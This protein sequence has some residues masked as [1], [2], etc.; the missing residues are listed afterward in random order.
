[1]PKLLKEGLEE[2]AIEVVG[3]CNSHPS[4]VSR[5]IS[6]I[7]TLVC[8]LAA[9]SISGCA[10]QKKADCAN[11]KAEQFAVQK[12]DPS[13]WEKYAQKH[14]LNPA[15]S[16]V[17]RLAYEKEGDKVLPCVSDLLEN[18][19]RSLSLLAE[20]SENPITGNCSILKHPK[21]DATVYDAM[22]GRMKYDKY[23]PPFRSALDSKHFDPRTFA[24]VFGDSHGWEE[25]IKFIAE[26][27]NNPSY[28]PRIFA[29]LKRIGSIRVSTYHIPLIHTF[30]ELARKL[31]IK[32]PQVLFDFEDSLIK[33]FSSIKTSPYGAPTAANALKEVIE[34]NPIPSVSAI[35]RDIVFLHGQSEGWWH[36]YY[37]LEPIVKSPKYSEIESL[38]PKFIRDEYLVT[39]LSYAIQNRNFD[40][41]QIPAIEKAAK[42]TGKNA[43]VLGSYLKHHDFSKMQAALSLVQMYSKHDKSAAI[44]NALSKYFE[45]PNFEFSN[46]QEVV[47]L[48]IEDQKLDFRPLSSPKADSK[49]LLALSKV[50]AATPEDTDDSFGRSS[51]IDAFT[52]LLGKNAFQTWMLDYALS[53]GNMPYTVHYLN[54][55]LDKITTSY[56]K[57]YKLACSLQAPC[58]DPVVYLN[59]AYGID[60]FGEDKVKKL[61]QQF[62]IRYFSRYKPE[63]LEEMLSGKPSSKPPLLAV[64]T[65]A[66]WNGAFTHPR[67]LESLSEN[68]NLT[69]IETGSEEE[70]LQRLGV[71]RS[72]VAIISAHGF[73]KSIHLGAGASEKAYIDLNDESD[74]KKLSS[75]PPLMI[76]NSCS[77]G[78]DEK[79]IGAMLS[80]VLGTTVYAPTISTGMARIIIKGGKVVDV[81][82]SKSER[83]K[84]VGGSNKPE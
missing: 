64:F 16:E 1:M 66:D 47:Y 37:N 65:I 81:E 5:R 27:F 82:Y 60:V 52:S 41:S 48:A 58:N 21:M 36:I 77:T 32:D 30:N 79:S 14:N 3:E 7:I 24:K 63:I 49:V 8:S 44:L 43:A 59:F 80:K 15:E 12:V 39:L 4:R 67:F 74:F 57:A 20:F 9:A 83:S 51:T 28:D 45:N 26:V 84:F 70:V 31:A 55:V 6:S 29:S 75:S 23:I 13:M 54:S 22:D 69:I 34:A 68:F 25:D 10:S 35:A 53:H 78:K 11:D 33:I 71:M 42:Q 19:K 76:L 73:D 50:L 18:K 56:D 38:L 46:V 72:G 17:L 2:V 61:Y 40:V 62:G